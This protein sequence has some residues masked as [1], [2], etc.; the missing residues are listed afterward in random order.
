MTEDLQEHRKVLGY[1]KWAEVVRDQMLFLNLKSQY[2]DPFVEED[3]SLLV[4]SGHINF[5][6]LL[7]SP[8]SFVYNWGLPLECIN[9]YGTCVIFGQRSWTLM[10]WLLLE[11]FQRW[12]IIYNKVVYSDCNNPATADL[13]IAAHRRALHHDADFFFF[14]FIFFFASLPAPRAPTNYFRFFALLRFSRICYPLYSLSISPWV[15]E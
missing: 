5:I 13:K 6:N 12:R 11:P 10:W 4:V 2:G 3:L 14:V 8:T 9:N 15:D 1:S 7:N